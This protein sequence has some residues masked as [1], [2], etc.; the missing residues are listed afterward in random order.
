MCVYCML[1]L[2][3]CKYYFPKRGE[4]VG[5]CACSLYIHIRAY[6]VCVCMYG[7]VCVSVCMYV[8]INVKS[9]CIYACA[10]VYVCMCAR[11]CV[12]ECVYECNIACAFGDDLST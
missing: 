1:L 10:S 12:C 9:V 11:V 7:R 4:C 2:H 3:V 5:M 6:V 8:L